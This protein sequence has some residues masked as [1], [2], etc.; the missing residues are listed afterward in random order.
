[1]ASS[2]LTK[3]KCSCINGQ[4]EGGRLKQEELGGSFGSGPLSSGKTR[5]SMLVRDGIRRQLDRSQKTEGPAPLMT[6]QEPRGE[7]RLLPTFVI[8][9]L[10]LTYA[11][12][13]A[14]M[15]GYGG[16]LATRIGPFLGRALSEAAIWL[17]FALIVGLAML[18]ER[19]PLNNI[20][21][22][23]VT[24]T[25]LGFGLGSLVL[26][27][28]VGLIG[29]FLVYTVLRLPSH[30]D[31]QAHSM[32]GSSI[33]YAIFLGLRAGIIEETLFRGPAIEQLTSLTGDRRVAAAVA[34]VAFVLV[35]LVHFDLAQL[36]PISMVAAI[37]T[38]L[39]LWRHDLIANIIAHT[40]LDGIGLV[41]LVSQ[42]GTTSTSS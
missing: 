18:W 38:G 30:A 21:L 16:R 8:L 1:M 23:R 33:V 7:G 15:Q 35:H 12:Y 24:L 36:L 17:Y 29:D 5:S 10:I 34:F 31:A 22:R 28:L 41:M 42:G 4:V 11:F 2:R 39:Y 32:V 14:W 26:L 13:S 9:V 19:R 3:V 27:F 37:L 6:F 20:G 40:L 25:T